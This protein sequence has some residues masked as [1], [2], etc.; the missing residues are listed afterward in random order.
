MRKYILYTA[1]LMTV[2]LGVN[3]QRLVKDIRPGTLGSAISNL[4][5]MGNHVYFVANHPSYGVELWKTDGT[6]A[7]TV[8]VKD[9]N[10]GPNDALYDS[11]TGTMS[12]LV[13]MGDHL[14][15]AADDGTHGHELWKS[16]GTDAG[17]V[18]V[19]DL[20]P[21]SGIGVDLY[22][23]YATQNTIYFRG[24]VNNEWELYK[25]DGTAAGTMIV[26]D[27]NTL[28]NASSYVADFFEY[29]GHV[30]F[31][32]YE[33]ASG[34]EIWKTDG[35]APGTVL[36]K[37]I[38]PGVGASSTFEYPTIYNGELYFVAISG[39]LGKE[40][41]KTDGTTNGTQIVK[42]ICANACSGEPSYLSVFNNKLFFTGNS[43]SGTQ[44][45]SSDGT[46]INTSMF[47][48]LSPG[49]PSIATEII[50]YKG[51]GYFQGGSTNATEGVELWITDGTV[52]GTEQ[53]LNINNA[54]FGN[55]HPYNFKV[56]G[57]LLFF[58]AND[59]TNGSEL[60]STDGTTG[61]TIMYNIS[62]GGGSSSPRDIVALGDK[63][64]FTAINDTTGRE[65]FAIDGL[66][67]GIANT[68]NTLQFSIYPNPAH[69]Q[70][71]ITAEADS[72]IAIVD[73]QGRQVMAQPSNGPATTLDVSSLAQ[74]MYVVKVTAANGETGLRK[75]VKE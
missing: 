54:P 49:Q 5:R 29:N 48:E 56:A 10:T 22:E 52:A 61:G 43:G 45:W 50:P 67:V 16:D 38:N 2:C 65:L 15:F 53:F 26:K 66:Q 74:G 35:T 21:G 20:N 9:I 62:P 28:A 27:I 19:A 18:L 1:L 24:H 11:P 12:K 25:S 23:I 71:V 51:K 33:S 57:G 46:A 73:L 58:S 72:H 42:D 8:M 31:T 17:T 64:L 14:Y 55:S 68:P 44:M 4:T 13:V 37:D 6:T 60:W 39:S 3:A 59:G 63:L 40:L 69:S 36:L 75:F 7:G 47:K 32:A 34:K 30:Y 70:L 41:Y